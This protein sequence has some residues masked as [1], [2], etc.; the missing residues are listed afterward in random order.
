[1]PTISEVSGRSNPGERCRQCGHP[2]DDHVMHAAQMP[3]P[4]NGWVTCPLPGCACY[5]TWSVSDHAREP[6]ERRR[7]EALRDAGDRGAG[8]SSPAT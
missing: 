5:G 3:Y 7:A 4:T 8:G 6:L 1:M 2:E